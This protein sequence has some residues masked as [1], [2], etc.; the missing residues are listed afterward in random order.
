VCPARTDFVGS[1]A[2]QL[3]HRLG[4]KGK[5]ADHPRFDPYRIWLDLPGNQRPPTYYQLLGIA[6]N[7]TDPHTVE[8]AA[9]RRTSQIRIFQS[10]RHARECVQLLNE[11][12]EAEA[13]LLNPAKR[14]VYDVLLKGKPR[15]Q[16][17]C[18]C[19]A[20]SAQS[21]AWIPGLER[22][23]ALPVPTPA[24]ASPFAELFDPEPIIHL[25]PRSRRQFQVPQLL[26][27]GIYFACLLVAGVLG[28]CLGR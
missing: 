11:I 24:A 19:P 22:R 15:Q 10:G 16:T 26:L 6:A 13:T 14:E 1:L 12:A 9:I 18:T 21:A 28:F 3:Q 25:A 27:A 20:E 17:S 4:M 5:V 2:S 23:R 7:E 8:E